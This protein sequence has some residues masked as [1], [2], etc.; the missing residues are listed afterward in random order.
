MFALSI[1][2][3]S[4]HTNSIQTK[5]HPT[6]MFH[7]GI[8]SAWLLQCVLI[9]ACIDRG[10]PQKVMVAIPRVGR[11]GAAV[12]G[13]TK[14]PVTYSLLGYIWATQNTYSYCFHTKTDTSWLFISYMQ[15]L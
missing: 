2:K 6:N 9:F 13:K 7:I 4:F 12:Q 11:R 5:A 8:S 3:G 14:A 15:P 1:W 10:Q